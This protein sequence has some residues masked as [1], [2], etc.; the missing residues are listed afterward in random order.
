MRIY[1]SLNRLVEELKGTASQDTFQT[2]AETHLTLKISIPLST[3]TAE[4]AVCY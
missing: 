3:A 4:Q 1:H 2:A